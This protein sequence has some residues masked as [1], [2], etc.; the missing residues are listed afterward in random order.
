[1]MLSEV[2]CGNRQ[3]VYEIRLQQDE[4]QTVHQGQQERLISSTK[5]AYDDTS[6]C[7]VAGNNKKI[8]ATRV[9]L[10]FDRSL[11]NQS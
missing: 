6:E 9:G 3:A 8:K 4:K 5:A 7:S 2:W 10:S 1:M 11:P